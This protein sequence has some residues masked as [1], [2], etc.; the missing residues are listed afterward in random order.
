MHMVGLGSSLD[1]CVTAAQQGT[2]I[3]HH[4]NCQV[5]QQCREAASRVGALVG[6]FRHLCSSKSHG[7]FVMPSSN[8][9]PS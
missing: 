2:G 7:R 6:L 9:T 1:V 5:L 3:L 4:H 8:A